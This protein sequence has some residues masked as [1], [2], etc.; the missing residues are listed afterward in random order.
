MDISDHGAAAGTAV[1]PYSGRR[2]ARFL[3]RSTLDR[4]IG[5]R[6]LLFEDTGSAG[7][8]AKESLNFSYF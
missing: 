7:I 8:L 2:A 6:R 4:R 3:P 5:D 1:G